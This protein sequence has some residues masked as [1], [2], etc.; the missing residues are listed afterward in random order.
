MA[1]TLSSHITALRAALVHAEAEAARTKAINADLAARIALLELQNE[2]MRRAFYGQRSERGQLFVDQLELGLEELE[3]N[4]G[5][6]E[7]LA[8]RAAASA[9]RVGGL[10]GISS[11]YRRTKGC[12]RG[13]GGLSA[14]AG[15]TH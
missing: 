11:A 7:A 4:A 8:Q 14:R 1:A 13:Q 10:R 9:A 2:K 6:D 15:A 3:A 12:T 5:E